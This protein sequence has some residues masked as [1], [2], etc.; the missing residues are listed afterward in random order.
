MK[1]LNRAQLEGRKKK[2]VRFV[3]DVLRGRDRAD[4]IDEESLDTEFESYERELAVKFIQQERGKP[5][6]GVDVE[7]TWEGHEVGNGEETQYPVISVV[8]DDY[9]TGYPE[10]Y[11]QKCIE[12]F[13]RFDL[14][15]EI[16]EQNRERRA[17]LSDAEGPRVQL[18]LSRDGPESHTCLMPNSS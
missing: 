15:D 10:N 1:T 9:E 11:I 6:C 16:H 2:A 17:L 7:V 8:W 4:E 5:P 13:E 12:T 14:P 18:C 3:G